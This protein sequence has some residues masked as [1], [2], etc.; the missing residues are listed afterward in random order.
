MKTLLFT[1]EYPPFHGGVANYYGN[2]AKYWPIEEKLVVLDNGKHEL[3]NNKWPLSWLL[4]FPLLKRRLIKEKIDYLLVGQILPLGTL[5]YI[6]SWLVP[7]KYGV[8]LHGMDLA[9]A[10]R[11]PRKRFLSKLILNRA[12]KIISANS[13]VKEKLV[14]FIPELEYKTKIVNP[15]IEGGVPYVNPIEITEIRNTYNL[16]G[17]TILFS[18][19]RLVKR[20]GVDNVIKAI[21]EMPEE[22]SHNLIYF[23]AGEGAREQYLKDLIPLKYLKKIIFLGSLTESEKWAWLKLSDIF[24]MPS[25]DIA[26]DFEGFGIVYLEANLCGKPVIAGNSGGVKDAVVNEVTGLL[27]DPE[28]IGDIGAAIIR[29]VNDK[30][31]CEKLGEQGRER[32]IK[33][34]NW[35]KQ[36]LSISEFIK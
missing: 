18:L 9:L 28:N 13:Y 8:F 7:I 24:L 14:E 11:S 21:N 5:A 25:R 34:F 26:G 32:A 22:L 3:L 19:G 15:G 20:K 16:E 36:A 27:V 4:A 6:V 2:M 10:L 30:N 31:I 17:K 35:E 33:D 1:L 29:L 23:I 12:D